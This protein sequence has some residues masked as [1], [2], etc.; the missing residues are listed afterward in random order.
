VNADPALLPHSSALAWSTRIDHD[1][2]AMIDFLKTDHNHAPITIERCQTTAELTEL[3]HGV[4][5]AHGI[6]PNKSWDELVYELFDIDGTASLCSFL[7]RAITEWE[8]LIDRED[9]E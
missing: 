7:S 6:E 3:V 1:A 2:K 9:L 8:D 5:R 4:I